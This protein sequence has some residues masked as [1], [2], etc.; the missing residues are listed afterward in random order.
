[1]V[2]NSQNRRRDTLEVNPVP[3]SLENEILV[4]NNCKA[5]S[6]TGVNVTPEQLHSC[7]RLK[8]RNRVIVKFICRKQRQNVL[9]NRKTLKDNLPI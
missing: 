5:L 4:E 9:F 1:M 3:E 8:K 6:L 7:H 2:T